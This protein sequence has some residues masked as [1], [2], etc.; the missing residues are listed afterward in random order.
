MMTDVA[1]P[2]YFSILFDFIITLKILFHLHFNNFIDIIYIKLHPFKTCNSFQY[3]HKLYNHIFTSHNIF[4]SHA[5]IIIIWF[6]T[7]HY[8]WNKISSIPTLFAIVPPLEN[9]HSI[10][11]P[12]WICLYWTSHINAIIPIVF[13]DQIFHLAW[14]F[15]NPSYFSMYWYFICFYHWLL[16]HCMVKLY[17][18]SQWPSRIPSIVKCCW[19]ASHICL[20]ACLTFGND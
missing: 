14:C 8:P 1:G 6:Q 7:F 16:L 3:I 2:H 15:W 18:V 12:L 20:L 10:F 13:C 17:F 9:L 11:L 19:I 5:S 4:T